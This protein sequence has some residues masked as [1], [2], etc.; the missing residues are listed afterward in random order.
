M[1]DKNI[2]ELDKLIEELTAQN[3][4]DGLDH[5]NGHLLLSAELIKRNITPNFNEMSEYLDLFS[6]R[7]TPDLSVNSDLVRNIDPSIQVEIL[8]KDLEASILKSIEE[9]YKDETNSNNHLT[10]LKLFLLEIEKKIAFSMGNNEMFFLMK[11]QIEILIQKVRA[12]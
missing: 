8:M 3:I 11:N 2:K 12:F 10:I 4:A 6:K 9:N 1:N 7:L 5:K